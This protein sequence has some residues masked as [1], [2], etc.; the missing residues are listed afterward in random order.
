MAT[1][2]QLLSLNK[3]LPLTP[4][5]KNIFA[6]QFGNTIA[7]LS[8]FDT[9]LNIPGKTMTDDRNGKTYFVDQKY[10]VKGGHLIYDLIVPAKSITP[11]V[12]ATGNGYIE[13]E[14]KQQPGYWLQDDDSVTV[15]FT[16]SNT[17]ATN[18][19]TPTFVEGWFDE[20]KGIE[21]CWNG[22][23]FLTIPAAQILLEPPIKYTNDQYSM[24]VNGTNHDANLLYTSVASI[25]ATAAPP[26]TIPYMVRLPSPFPKFGWWLGAMGINGSDNTLT[27]RIWTPSGGVVDSGSG[28]LNLVASNLRLST[29]I[30]SQFDQD[31]L[32]TKFG[33]IKYRIHRCIL[34]RPNTVTLVASGKSPNV[35][36]LA[37]KDLETTFAIVI[38]HA[39]R[40]VTGSAYYNIATV[41]T[42]AYAKHAMYSKEGNVI[43]GSVDTPIAYDQ[44]L[45][46]LRHFDDVKLFVNRPYIPIYIMHKTKEAIE[47]GNIDGTY[48]WTGDENYVLTDSGSTATLYL[49]T[50]AWVVSRVMFDENGFT[51]Q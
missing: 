51:I 50:L 42:N 38:P 12:L 16:V 10:M 9:H 26:A 36:Q 8:V 31:A 5:L 40:S 6:S 14:I 11:T 25:A 33:R 15:E 2:G 44:W 20:I 1:P 18:T 7:Q 46:P 47:E 34:N 24:Y 45:R 21:W 22:R 13:Y 32:R 17:H 28:T 4:D 3:S 27:V 19:V 41:K 30:L 37:L 49:D 48:I 39:S 35:Q 23:P 43:F 29:F